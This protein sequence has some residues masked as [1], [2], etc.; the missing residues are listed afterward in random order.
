M[1]NKIGK[2]GVS[3]ID[4]F[5]RFSLFL[6]EIVRYWHKI[7]ADELERYGLKGACAVYFTALY[8]YPEGITAK[9]LG[10]MC[11][12]DKSDVSRAISQMEQKGLVVKR[13]VN[14]NLYRARLVLTEDGRA[15]AEHINERAQRA[16]ELGGK[17]L[18]DE[19]RAI[20]YESLARIAANLQ[21]LSTEG[22][23]HE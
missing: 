1:S 16:V 18:S 19:H 20:F 9:Q 8:R 12:K 23:P 6:S 2:E 11:G 15:A 17:G 10:E 14:D 21:T 22:L 5:E 7:A 3:V 13:G 4:R